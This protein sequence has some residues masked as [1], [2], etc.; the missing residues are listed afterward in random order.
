MNTALIQPMY[1]WNT[2]NWKKAQRKVFKLQKRIYQASLR[3][4]VKLVRSLQRLLIRSWSARLLAVR[5][6]T[7]DN[8]G[9]KTAG[10]DGVKSLTPPQ[11]LK[12]V[13]KLRP[14]HKA[15]PVRRVYINKPGKDEKRP[16]GIPVIHDR[17]LQALVLLA[18][19]PEWEARFE[20]NSYGF[21]P[22]R[23]AWDAIA[24]IF[25]MIRLKP[26]WA[27]DADIAACYDRINHQALL[28]KLNTSPSIRRQIRAWLK[29]GVIDGGKLFPT[30]EGV[31][32]GGIISPLLANVALHG[33]EEVIREAF[34]Q[35]K[36]TPLVVRYA[37]DL[38]VLHPDR[39]VIECCQEILS[40]WLAEMGLEL[41]PAK[42]RISHTLEKIEGRVGFDFLG[43]EI[44]QYRARKRRLGF[45]TIIKP[46]KES[47]LRHL[48]EIREVIGKH[49][50]TRQAILIMALNRVIVGWS[51]YYSTVCS[52]ESY[53][54]VD[55][56]M[57]NRL[58][59]WI[60]TRQ[61]DESLKKATRKYWRREGGKLIFSPKNDTVRLR[62]H[63][64]T[65]IKRHV[66]VKG[67][68]SPYDGDWAYWSARMGHHP[69]VS[70]RVGKLVKRQ[71]GRCKRCG[72][73]LRVEDVVEVD[74]IIPKEEGGREC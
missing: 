33:M 68:R 16:L 41:K 12:L 70:T 26:K 43:F 71:K 3:G 73:S 38:V 60:L 23:S 53:S 24:A 7:Q 27:L 18:L 54:K 46:S 22:G 9:K 45:K 55:L 61:K 52:K 37:D 17:A 5:R 72:L 28:D 35:E 51:R 32:Q 2:L 57:M 67:R 13:D 50:M 40:E 36:N 6:V 21:R 34:A 65:K 56:M 4:D 69:G 49:R 30:Q 14:G 8:R 15:A 29:A 39:E 66:K 20:P 62:F 31:P 10:V 44:R 47:V 64:E 74:H 19:E 58:R 42:T 25:N 59:A 63:R 11:R 48:R 1:G